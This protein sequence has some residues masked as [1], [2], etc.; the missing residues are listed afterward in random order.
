[1]SNTCNPKGIQSI[2]K[3]ILSPGLG[4]ITSGFQSKGGS[5]SRFVLTAAENNSLVH[6][7]TRENGSITTS[8]ENIHIKGQLKTAP[9]AQRRGYSRYVHSQNIVR[10]PTTESETEKKVSKGNHE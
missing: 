10:R 5:P 4:S 6:S 9:G 7:T 8:R 2:E 3:G 1:M